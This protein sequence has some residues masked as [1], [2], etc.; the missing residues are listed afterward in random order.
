MIVP[1]HFGIGPASAEAGEDGFTVNTRQRLG[2]PVMCWTS[3]M[4]VSR[5]TKRQKVIDTVRHSDGR[6]HR[7]TE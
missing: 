4:F 6:I 7:K 3:R 2:G 5:L 1:I